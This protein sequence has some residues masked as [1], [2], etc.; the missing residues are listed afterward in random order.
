MLPALNDVGHA[1]TLEEEAALL[2]AC[3]RSRCRCLYVA[4]MLALN[5]GMRYSEIRLLG[6]NKWTLWRGF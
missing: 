6:G 1:I 5:S 4:V 2:T 3:L